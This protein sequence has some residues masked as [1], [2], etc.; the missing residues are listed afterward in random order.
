MNLPKTNDNDGIHKNDSYMLS[1]ILTYGQ[2]ARLGYSRKNKNGGE[3]V[4]DILF[5]HPWKFC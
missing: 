5:F 4:E 3:G 1:A 2:W